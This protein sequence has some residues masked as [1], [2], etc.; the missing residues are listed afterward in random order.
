MALAFCIA[1]R[2]W[3][4][5]CRGRALCLLVAI[6]AS[7]G[8]A[9]APAAAADDRVAPAQHEASD[10]APDLQA[11]QSPAAPRV[12]VPLHPADPAQ[13]DK[14]FAIGQHTVFGVQSEELIRSGHR[15][16][17]GTAPAAESGLPA[18]DA[19]SPPGS[20]EAAAK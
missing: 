19:A 9:G 20:P 17:D 13:V 1:D 11:P 3:W 2:R 6:L 14:Q 8:T 18:K 12:Y 7:I 4:R 15:D 10:A 5:N 16:R